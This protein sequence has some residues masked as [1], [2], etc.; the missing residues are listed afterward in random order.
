MGRRGRRRLTAAA[1]LA[2]VALAVAFVVPLMSG[3]NQDLPMIGGEGSGTV[4]LAPALVEP[5]ES[6]A[7]HPPSTPE[8]N[9][10]PNDVD[11]GSE[12]ETPGNLPAENL[13]VNVGSAN[14]LYPGHKVKLGVTYVN[15]YSFP[16]AIDEV[17]VTA[18]GTARCP[19]R[20]LMP[21]QQ[22][23]PGLRVPSGSSVASTVG[24][25]MRKSAPDACQG[26]RFAVRVNVT[27]V[28]L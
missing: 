27:A 4:S 8:S 26:M 5:R 12:G 24:V 21:T 15:P 17:H 2:A 9:L 23:A 25:G 28:Q 20:Y 1:I 14:G 16:I 18:T 3:D 6:A 10:V 13:G 11:E 7:T 22:P 19:A